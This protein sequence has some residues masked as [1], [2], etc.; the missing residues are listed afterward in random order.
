MKVQRPD[1]YDLMRQGTIAR[2]IPRHIKEEQV[3]PHVA[4]N[5]IHIKADI[6]INYVT[7]SNDIL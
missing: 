3:C 6:F 7:S 2:L 4:N 1:T 5:V